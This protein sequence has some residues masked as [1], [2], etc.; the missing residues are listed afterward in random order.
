MSLKLVF[1]LQIK[2]GYFCMTEI[3]L[4]MWNLGSYPSQKSSD[5]DHTSH[6]LT[7]ATRE[8]FNELDKSVKPVA[9][10]QFWMVCTLLLHYLQHLLTSFLFEKLL[11]IQHINGMKSHYECW[12]HLFQTYY[13]LTSCHICGVLLIWAEEMYSRK[14][15]CC[16]AKNSDYMDVNIDLIY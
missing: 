10:M 1:K 15:E 8:L 2:C 13:C 5:L 3:L 16:R 4:S 11:V 7:A 12:T 9:P 14:L 6:M